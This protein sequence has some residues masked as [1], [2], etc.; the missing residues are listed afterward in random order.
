MLGSLFGGSK[1]SSAELTEEGRWAYH[2][3]NYSGAIT[4]FRKALQVDPQ[5]HDC[6]VHL[7]NTYADLNQHENAVR[8]YQ[9]AVSLCKSIPE[10][11]HFMGGSYS[12]LGMEK[13][14]QECY[15]HVVTVRP[16]FADAW[17]L[18]G[19]SYYLEGTKLEASK[20]FRKYIE[21]EPQ[22]DFV[23]LAYE[24]LE[25]LPREESETSPPTD[26]TS[27]DLKDFADSTSEEIRKTLTCEI[28]KYELVYF[29]Q[30]LVCDLLKLAN[31]EDEEYWTLTG[32]FQRKH[33]LYEAA[34][35]LAQMDGEI[36]NELNEKAII[37]ADRMNEYK[38]KHPLSEMVDGPDKDRFLLMFLT[39]ASRYFCRTYVDSSDVAS[40][41]FPI[42]K[43]HIQRQQDW[44]QNEF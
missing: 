20:C 22:G 26:S 17:Y 34:E 37:A 27:D 33:L 18:L 30:Y 12:E 32:D 40:T 31:I 43:S 44:Q 9:K 11:F 10:Y 4:L 29:M 24:L 13:E 38:A 21:L 6:M 16:G 15:R 42:I 3:G 8:Y 2:D 23:Q 19:T 36:T 1:K 39:Q 28:D 25:K 14:A 35:D 41:I 5:N 7:A